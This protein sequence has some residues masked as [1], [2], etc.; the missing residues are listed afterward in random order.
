MTLVA[1]VQPDPPHKHPVV[2]DLVSIDLKFTKDQI[3]NVCH[4]INL[5]SLLSPLAEMIKSPD[6]FLTERR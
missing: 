2:H 4:L 5:A 6:E 3:M 1:L